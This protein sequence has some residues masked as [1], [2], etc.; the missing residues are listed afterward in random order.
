MLGPLPRAECER[1]EE[2]VAEG[3]HRPDRSLRARPQAVLPAPAGD[4]SST[5]G[6]SGD[7]RD[8]H[9]VTQVGVEA[10]DDRRGLMV[11]QDD[12]HEIVVAVALHEGDQG[13][14]GVLDGLAVRCA[15]F[16]RCRSRARPSTRF[17]P[18]CCRRPRRRR[19]PPTRP[20]VGCGSTA[21]GSTPCRPPRRADGGRSSRARGVAA[22]DRCTGRASERTRTSVRRTR[23]CAGRRPCRSRKRTTAA[24]RGR[25]PARSRPCAIRPA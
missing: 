2:A 16:G 22:P 6:I 13:V 21:H 8:R 11:S 20:A 24:T 25:S 10:G 4:L 7:D 19:R 15:H 18:A 12:E 1:A 14:Q 17:R 9:V 23:G 5:A 3:A